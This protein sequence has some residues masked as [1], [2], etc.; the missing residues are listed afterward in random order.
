MPGLILVACLTAFAGPVPLLGQPLEDVV[1]L[2]NGTIVRGTI[3]EQVPGV[4]LKIQTTGGSMF[5]YTLEEIAKIVKE[6][7]LEPEVKAEPDPEPDDTTEETEEISRESVIELRKQIRVKK[8]E[9]WLAFALSLLMPGTGQ[10][11]NEQYKKGIPQ[12]GAVIAGAG[13]VYIG[14]E[15]NY[16][17]WDGPW[18]DPDDDN[19]RVAVPGGILWACA[20]LWSV[21]DAPL[22]AIRINKQSQPLVYG[23]L[24]EFD[25]D[26]ATLGFDPFAWQDGSGAR[27][28]LHF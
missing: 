8:K 5:F 28:T 15:D 27:L 12:L 2:K 13:L 16:K 22:S 4:S 21:I 9:P 20:H 11:Y 23:H 3:V 24:L 18:V 25:L 10:F 19:V 26:R 17:K 7:V 6:P 1:Y 14:I